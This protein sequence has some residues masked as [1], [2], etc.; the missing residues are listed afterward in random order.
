MSALALSCVIFLLVLGGIFIGTAFRRALPKNHLS[1]ETHDVVRLG[2]G[3]T[4]TIAALVLGLLIGGAKKFVRH[5][6]QSS[7]PAYSKRYSARQFVG[8]V[9]P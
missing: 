5:K 1:K 9:R 8:T 4:A 2:A 7:Q 3:L 6:E